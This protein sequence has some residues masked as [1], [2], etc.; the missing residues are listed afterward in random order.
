MIL[1]RDPAAVLEGGEIKSHGAAKRQRPR[2]RLMRKTD[3]VLIRAQLDALNSGS[4][5]SA[6]APP[7]R[8]GASACCR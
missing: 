2:R 4:A 1:P 7:P 6:A 3:A 5:Q 8:P